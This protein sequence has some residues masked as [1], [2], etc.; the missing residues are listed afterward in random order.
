ML[1]EFQRL[2]K[3]QMMTCRRVEVPTFLFRQ[4]GIELRKK[5]STFSMA[6]DPSVTWYP[7]ERD[8]NNIWRFHDFSSSKDMHGDIIDFLTKYLHYR[9]S[10]AINDLIRYLHLVP[11]RHDTDKGKQVESP[12]TQVQVKMKKIVGLNLPKPGLDDRRVIAYLASV[13]HIDTK[14]LFDCI[15][16]KSIYQDEKGNAVFVGRDKYGQ[17][18]YA[19]MRGTLSMGDPFKGEAKGSDKSYGFCITGN[20][21]KEIVTC[22]ESAIDALSYASLMRKSG[23]GYG[24]LLALGGVTD[25]ALAQY[26]LD[27]KSC[28]KII[29]RLDND[30]A[31]KRGAAVISDRYRKS[32]D[33]QTC[34]LPSGYKDMNDLLCGLK[35]EDMER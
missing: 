13:R 9:Y 15:R 17:A 24:D 27:H 26:L 14:I 32:Y 2:D 25:K 23:K 3:N 20:R 8:K 31:G 10:D 35:R 16:D 19:Y 7:P 11:N 28:K 6:A 4:Y 5:G 1:S 34:Q 12:K 18:R 29:L 22:F 33:I 21:A 30:I